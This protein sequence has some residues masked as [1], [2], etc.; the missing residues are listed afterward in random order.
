VATLLIPFTFRGA[1]DFG[2]PWFAATAILHNGD[3]YRLIGPDG[4]YVYQDAFHLMYP[5]TAAVAILPLGFLQQ[6]HAA[7][8]FS[9]VS[10]FLFTYAITAD[11]WGRLPILLSMP[12]LAAAHQPQWSPILAAG[13]CLPAMAW[14]FAAKPTLG[15]ALLV[16][17]GSLPTFRTALVGGAV[18]LLVSLVCVSSWPGEWL[19]VVASQSH[20]TA[21]ILQPGGFIA[22]AALLRWRR[23]EARLITALACV[24]QTVAW[25]DAAVLLLVAST[26]RESLL[27][28]VTMSA[29][30]AY[31]MMFGLS[32]RV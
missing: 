23:P 20:M 4:S 13:F 6:A 3:P 14:I 27:L 11:G 9:W 25:Y 30:L 5:L 15:A 19:R 16:S 1:G 21:P 12:F 7:V 8:V 28:A 10:S 2:A 32:D 24:P 26:F 18:L 22:A 29:P 17:T 31:E